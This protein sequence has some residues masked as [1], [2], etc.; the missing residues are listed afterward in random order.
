MLFK[1]MFLG[2]MKLIYSFIFLNLLFINGC[3]TKSNNYITLIEDEKEI[4][5]SFI[6]ISQDY[7]VT[8]K[9][10]PK[11]PDY[12]YISG[13]YDIQFFEHKTPKSQVPLFSNYKE[14]E[15]IF[16]T[17]YFNGKY[18]EIESEILDIT[19]NTNTSSIPVYKAGIGTIKPGM[20]GG[21]VLNSERKVI[22]MNIGF[23]TE[24]IYHNNEYKKMSIFVPYEIIKKEWNK[25]LT[26]KK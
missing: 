8:V 14:N 4:N 22:G 24:L 12:V 26:L 6:P 23:T 17:G 3:S 20:S 5:A 1:K 18:N 10:I 19:V 21:A 16:F 11:H 9:H 7:A 25:Y 15:K 2:K 13:K